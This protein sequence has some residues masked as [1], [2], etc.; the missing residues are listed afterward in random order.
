MPTL[1]A[2]S[3]ASLCAV[4]P[5]IC[6]VSL[7]SPPPHCH[8]GGDMAVSTCST[9][10]ALACSGGGWVLGHC[11]ISLLM[12]ALYPQ[13]TLQAGACR[14]GVGT[15]WWHHFP[16]LP[17]TGTMLFSG[18]VVP[19]VILP[20]SYPPCEQGLTAVV[21][22]VVVGVGV[23]P[24]PCQFVVVVPPV[25]LIVGWYAPALLPTSSCS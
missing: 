20:P 23:T 13:S 15:H 10:Q 4:V 3:G 16:L 9:L 22:V 25:S 19:S 1:L 21:V 12:L 7:W 6:H 24:V 18:I 5:S 2:V 11:L 14:C 17:C 8:G